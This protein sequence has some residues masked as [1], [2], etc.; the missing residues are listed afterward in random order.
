MTAL[1]AFRSFIFNI[2]MDAVRPGRRPVD[3]YEGENGEITFKIMDAAGNAV[4]LSGATAAYKIARR[5]Y[6]PGAVATYATGGSGITIE[7]NKVTVALAI[8]DSLVAGTYDDQL[9][10]TKD[11]KT[12]VASAGRFNIK[13]DI[14]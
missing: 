11:G 4:D 12:V 8:T 9:T 2:Y 1:S 10:L 5:G 6:G 7:G 14:V 13:S 3:L